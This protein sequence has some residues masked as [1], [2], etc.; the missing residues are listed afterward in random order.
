MVFKMEYNIL[1]DKIVEILNRVTQITKTV[2]VYY[3]TVLGGEEWEWYGNRFYVSP[4][5]PRTWHVKKQPLD[6]N[7]PVGNINTDD[8]AKYLSRLVRSSM[9]INDIRIVC[10]I[11]KQQAKIFSYNLYDL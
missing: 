7:P 4:Y 6:S 8:L 3:F 10:E 9:L 1:K 11:P 5:A 2:T